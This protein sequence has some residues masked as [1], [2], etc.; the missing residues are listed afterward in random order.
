MIFLESAFGATGD[1]ILHNFNVNCIFLKK[2]PRVLK[3]IFK[4][5]NHL[6]LFLTSSSNKWDVWKFMCL[7]ANC[8]DFISILVKIVILLK[9]LN[10]PP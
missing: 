8:N 4:K 7:H 2:S 3:K 5:K 1:E 9:K 6:S 10:A